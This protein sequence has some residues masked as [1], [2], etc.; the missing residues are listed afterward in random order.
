MSEATSLTIGT[1]GSKLALAQ[2]QLVIDALAQRFPDIKITPKVIVTK[3]DVDQSPIPQGAIGK[4]WFTAEIERALLGGEIDMAVHSMKDLPPAAP[5]ELA[6]LPVLRRG[7]ARDAL[8]T[9]SGAAFKDLPPGTV[10]G[11]D[12]VRRKALLLEQRPDLV[13]K[14]IRGNVDTRLRKL[15][16]EAYDAIVLAAAGLGRAGMQSAI[17]EL[18]DPLVFIPAIGQGILASQTRVDREDVVFL[19]RAI[20]DA[21][22]VIAADAEQAFA[23]TIGGGCKT[24]IGCYARVDGKTVFMDA[25]MQNESDMKIRRRS[26]STTIESAHKAAEDLAH[27]LL[28]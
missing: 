25:F 6:T 18:M 10:I 5:H 22:T 2:T 17:T 19:L 7:D 8:I 24:P 14:S 16:E 28:S 20:Q 4:D 12:S 9:R 3:G 13:I 21:P 23:T 27:A 15:H 11:T 1:R 26:I